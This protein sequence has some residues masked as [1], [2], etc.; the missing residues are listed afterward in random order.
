LNL[1]TKRIV[2]DDAVDRLDEG[3]NDFTARLG[4]VKLED[5]ADEF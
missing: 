2:T 1:L 5:E 3:F 4:R